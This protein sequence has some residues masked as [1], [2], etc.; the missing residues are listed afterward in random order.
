MSRYSKVTWSE[1]LFLRQH[2]FQ[3]ADRYVEHLLDHRTRHIS[4]YP[5][6]FSELV[7]DTDLAERN[8]FGLRRASGILP[9]GTPF[10]M[11]GSMPL[12]EA[13]DVPEG[14]DKQTLWL[15]VPTET[16]GMR[17]IDMAEARSGSRYVRDLETVVDAASA[18]HVEQEIEIAHLRAALDIRNAPK[19]GFQSLKIARILEVRDKTIT[20]DPAFAPAVLVTMAHGTVSGW[21][22]R[23]IGWVDTKLDSLAR[24][25]ADPGSG[26]GLQ[27]LDYFML[28]A[29]NRQVNV[30]KHM[31]RS[32]FV[33]PSE[34]Y[35]ELLRLSGELWTLSPSRRA[36][37][38]AAYDH[39]NLTETF[40]PV[41]GDI[42][43]LLSLDLARA[44]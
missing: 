13:I 4:P 36:P 6:G 22:D 10:D 20:L 8:Q 40:E 32:K 21:L 34:F 43:R 19:P 1:G 30:L 3:Q 26:G 39:D 27:A 28:Q 41:L 42:Q 24:Y 29:L 9:D 44:V 11:P 12:P 37:D 5:W 7:I 17:E 2:H 25:A 38:Y 31:R 23:V 14:A 33:H 15:T 35:R 18:M 16:A